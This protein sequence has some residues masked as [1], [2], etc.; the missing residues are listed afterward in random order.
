MGKS[1]SGRSWIM[2]NIYDASKPG[3]GEQYGKLL[4][5]SKESFW[6]SWFFSVCYKG[7]SSEGGRGSNHFDYGADE[8]M[9]KRKEILENPDGHVGKIAFVTFAP[10]EA[11]VFKGDAVFGFRDGSGTKFSD[12]GGK[13]KPSHMRIF[14]DD[15]GT[16]YGGNESN[17]VG[18][19]KVKIGPNRT[20]SGKYGKEPYVAVYKRVK[21]LGKGDSYS[22]NT[23]TS[24]SSGGSS[25]E[26]DTAPAEKQY[27]LPTGKP[28]SVST[29]KVGNK[30]IKM[31]K[32]T[33]SPYAVGEPGQGAYSG[34]FYKRGEGGSFVVVKDKKLIAK[35]KELT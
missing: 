26:G 35:L 18:K 30:D 27:N 34:A 33:G 9:K 16:V 8:G 5:T 21:V 4:G 2:K 14:G 1:D 22:G 24:S 31:R 15:G 13:P 20:V 6:S 12:I 3:S 28:G 25:G 17:R 10:N 19:G 32:W 29:R 11:P 23:S 7:F